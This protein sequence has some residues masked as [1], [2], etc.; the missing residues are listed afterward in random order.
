M[1]FSRHIPFNNSTTLAFLVTVG[2]TCCAITQSSA[3]IVH[4]S[5][6][7]PNGN[8]ESS[9]VQESASSGAVNG[10]VSD[11]LNI[12]DFWNLTREGCYAIGEKLSGPDGNPY[13]PNGSE[14]LASMG[15][16]ISLD[17]GNECQGLGYIG[18]TAGK[19]SWSSTYR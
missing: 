7:V 6:L 16:E 9:S 5:N 17:S 15:F 18:A 13:F 10:F 3:A 11:Y 4:P 14:A 2:F 12:R 8:F 19:S 1:V